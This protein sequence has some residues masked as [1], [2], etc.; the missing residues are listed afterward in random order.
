MITPRASF[1]IA[2]CAVLAALSLVLVTTLASRPFATG[3][4]SDGDAS[5]PWSS[6]QTVLPADLAK[7]L[8]VSEKSKKPTIIC[9][10]FRTLYE[11][12][13][14]PGAVFHGTASTPQ[15]S[16]ELKAFAQ[17]L[18]RSANLVLYC[19]CCPLQHCP[20]LKPAFT[21]LRDMG[22]T[23][24]RVLLLPTDFNSDWIEKGYPIEKGK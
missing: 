2:L 1:R 22:F 18:P 7:E 5:A 23:H 3:P 20:N 21:L 11:G 9:V 24:L 6:S 4:P 12:A 15:G 8:S 14:V 17:D 13:H 10:G 16:A 19:G